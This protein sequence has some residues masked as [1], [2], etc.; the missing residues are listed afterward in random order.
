MKLHLKPK[1]WSWA[2]RVFPL[3]ALLLL[4]LLISFDATQALDYVLIGIATISGT[5]AFFWF[6][7]VIDAI[8]NLNKFFTDSYA[9]FGDIQDHLRE[10]KRDVV[11]VKDNHKHD[12]DVI[13]KSKRKK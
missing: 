9:R 3:T 5:I 10:I 12:L 2:G 13:K 4:I 8:H 1:F 6:W 11:E 7:W